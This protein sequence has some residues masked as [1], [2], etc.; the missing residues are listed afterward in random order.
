MN[1]NFDDIFFSKA[2]TLQNEKKLKEAISMYREILYFNPNN[3]KALNNLGVALDDVGKPEEAIQVLKKLVKIDP[4]YYDAYYNMGIINKGMGL[5]KKAIA[6]YSA[7]IN[8]NSFGGAAYENRGDC[9]LLF[10]QKEKAAKDYRKAVEVK[11]PRYN[12]EKLVYIIN[13]NQ[14]N[15]I[16]KTVR[17]LVESGF[18]V[19]YKHNNIDDDIILMP[20]VNDNRIILSIDKIHIGKTIRKNIRKNQENYNL[21][22]DADFNLN[23][24]RLRTHYNKDDDIIFLNLLQKCLGTIN[25]D[26]GSSLKSVGV[27]LYENDELA[28]GE[29][30]IINKKLYYSYTGY[31]EK[32]NRGAAQIYLLSQVLAEKGVEI[33]CFGPSIYKW[34]PYKLRYGAKIINH[35]ECIKLFNK[36]NNNYNKDLLQN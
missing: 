6:N 10:N 17:I 25:K 7:A 19:R 31:H 5:I 1:Y 12:S 32:N 18:L 23:F 27:S 28:A 33:I 8:V 16:E 15:E 22:F 4:K 13:Q 30:G 29:I 26:N 3:I 2:V 9:Y 20:N 24:D 35:N 14:I 21:R 34:N 11:F 36:T